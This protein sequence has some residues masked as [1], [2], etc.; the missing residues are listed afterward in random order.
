MISKDKF[1][2]LVNLFNITCLWFVKKIIKIPYRLVKN[3]LILIFSSLININGLYK[4][5]FTYKYNIKE[6]KIFFN[7]LNFDDPFNIFQLYFLC[8]K[9]FSFM[10][11]NE[12]ENNLEL[13]IK[14][15][16]FSKNDLHIPDLFSNEIFLREDSTSLIGL[17]LSENELKKYLKLHNKK[18]T[19]FIN[20]NNIFNFKIVNIS[21]FDLSLLNK[22][23]IILNL[24]DIIGNHDKNIEILHKTIIK[25]LSSY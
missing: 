5:K 17:N 10:I 23:M 16:K 6:K 9:S 20:L 15:Y 7:Q 11:E 19:K 22:I 1:L 13:L 3:I 18:H 4:V 2:A 25:K 12:K 24:D 21:R 8:K 14:R